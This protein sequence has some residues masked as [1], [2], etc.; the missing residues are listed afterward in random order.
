MEDKKGGEA[1][2]QQ[3]EHQV[4]DAHVELLVLRLVHERGVGLGQGA[5]KELKVSER[6]RQGE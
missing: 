2:A 6:E 1:D 3:A 5:D 4:R